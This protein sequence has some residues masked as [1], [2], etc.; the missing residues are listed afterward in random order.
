MIDRLSTVLTRLTG[1]SLMLASL[2]AFA[3]LMFILFVELISAAFEMLPF[4]GVNSD[5]E[6]FAM[7]LVIIEP[8]A[9]AF[10]VYKL[11][12]VIGASGFLSPAGAMKVVA[13]Q[14]GQIPGMRIAADHMYK[15]ADDAQKARRENK[16]ENG[17]GKRASRLGRWSDLTSRNG[18]ARSVAR[19]GDLAAMAVDRSR[20]KRHERKG[21]DG[22]EFV[23]FQ[24][25]FDNRRKRAAIR[26]AQMFGL[27]DAEGKLSEPGLLH[28]LGSIAGLSSLSKGLATS[29][30][31]SEF[32]KRWASV[33]GEKD[34]EGNLVKEGKAQKFGRWWDPTGAEN[35]KVAE[36]TRARHRQELELLKG[37]NSK[38]RREFHERRAEEAVAT[39]VAMGD[40]VVEEFWTAEMQQKYGAFD[41]TNA[42]HRVKLAGKVADDMGVSKKQMLL[43]GGYVITNESGE[44]EYRGGATMVGPAVGRRVP[45]TT[46]FESAASLLRNGIHYL[47]DNT[48]DWVINGGP[49]EQSGLRASMVLHEAG[50]IDQEGNAVNMLVRLGVDQNS[51]AGQ[52]EIERARRGESS[53]LD[54]GVIS[55]PGTMLAKIERQIEIHTQKEAAAAATF[56]AR[57]EEVANALVTS[58]QSEF[59]AS[60]GKTKTL[61]LEAQTAARE[62]VKCLK[63]EV[64]DQEGAAKALAE[65][66]KKLAEATASL[67]SASASVSVVR[68]V[69][70]ERDPRN[71]TAGETLARVKKE[72]QI[73]HYDISSQLQG[74]VELVNTRTTN[75]TDPV[76]VTTAASECDRVINKMLNDLHRG[77]VDA[78]REH[79]AVTNI[80]RTDREEIAATAHKHTPDIKPRSAFVAGAADGPVFR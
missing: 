75:A 7:I 50:M 24:Q 20:R 70:I 46:S 77:A 2:W 62:A 15:K 6:F 59:T 53:R 58:K 35:S 3:L 1:S 78:S 18:L 5:V 40:A 55:I 36:N 45:E 17:P 61:Y 74:L 65:Y 14:V 79:K 73:P 57:E 72:A 42:Q 10:L 26:R 28:Q 49:P 66:R 68:A 11:F 19:T 71:D 33:F 37:A 12:E 64:P 21:K 31:D 43:G 22:E 48:K 41:A 67:G 60:Y 32:G 29:D 80:R 27:K 51:A 76:E 44:L 16:A 38:T 63:E 9:A 13:T 23:P 25:A 56:A 47:D 54:D 8:G 39:N 4:G 30:T 52:R 69:A 34:Q